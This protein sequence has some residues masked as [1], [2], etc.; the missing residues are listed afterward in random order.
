MAT[1]NRRSEKMNF[2]IK[3]GIIKDNIRKN[4]EDKENREGRLS[5]EYD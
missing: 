3:S 1:T 4:H 5:I 2:N